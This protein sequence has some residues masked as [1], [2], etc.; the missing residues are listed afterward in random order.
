MNEDLENLS[1]D[2]LFHLVHWR[3]T[4]QIPGETKLEFVYSEG[5]Y[6]Q[7]SLKDILEKKHSGC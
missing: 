4:S 3:N 2:Q 5:K 7:E 6:C 1:K